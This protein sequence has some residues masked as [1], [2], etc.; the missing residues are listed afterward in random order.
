[1]MQKSSIFSVLEIFF[2]QPST[3]HFIREIAKKLGISQ[4]P[5]RKVI[6]IL[7]KENLIT[8]KKS[9][10]FDGFIACR[11]DEKFKFYKRAY[12]LYSLYESREKIIEEIHPKA[13]ILFGSYVRGE[14]IEQSDI[15]LLIISKIKKEL[16]LNSFEKKLERNIHLIFVENVEKLDKPLQKN[17][18]NGYAIYGGYNEWRNI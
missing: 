7:E 10:P 14:D 16:D 8:K 12:N 4:T 18:K 13:I 2:K 1:M 15:D 17:I 5:V 9:I 3:I 11:D 6:K